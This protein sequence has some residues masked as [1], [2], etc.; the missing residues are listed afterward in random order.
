MRA[1]LITLFMTASLTACAMGRPLRETTPR[2]KAD[3]AYR[4][5]KK[6]WGVANPLGKFCNRRCLE[7]KKRKGCIKWELNIL[8]SMKQKDFDFMD[9][10]SFILIDE[11]QVL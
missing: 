7:I 2:K 5:C 11:D 6:R 1:L 8:D 4:P 3:K 10:G 9:N